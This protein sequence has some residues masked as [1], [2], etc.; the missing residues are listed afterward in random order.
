MK[1]LDINRFKESLERAPWD[2][3]FV[4][5]DVDDIVYAWENIF[6]TIVDLHCPWREK[7]VKQATQPPWITK[8]VISQLRNRDVLLK[9]ARRS[10][11]TDDGLIIVLHETKLS[12]FCVLQSV[13]FLNQLLR[14]IKITDVQFG[15]R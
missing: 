11:D 8:E 13:S 12:L 1:C 6:N 4:F 15:R 10:N 3:T 9:V 5:E 7:R 2:T 14:K